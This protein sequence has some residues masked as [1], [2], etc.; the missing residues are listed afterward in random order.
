MDGCQDYIPAYT[1]VP[2]DRSR[3]GNQMM[4]MPGIET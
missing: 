3:G 1:R 2:T 4:K